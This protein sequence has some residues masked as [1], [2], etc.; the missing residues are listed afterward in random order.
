M[1][2]SEDATVEVLR[3]KTVP[4][5]LVAWATVVQVSDIQLKLQITGGIVCLVDRQHVNSTYAKLVDNFD[6]KTP[7]KKANEPPKL[8][9]LFHKGQQYV[10]KILER[11]TRA[12]YAKAQDI[13][14]TL[15]PSHIQEDNLPATMLSIANVPLQGV[16]LSIED[17]GYHVDIGFK[18]VTAFLNFDQTE[19]GSEGEQF[20]VGQVIRCC[21]LEAI[22]LD[23]NETRVV[24]LSTTKAMFKKAHFSRDK[25]GQTL[26]TQKCVLPGSTGFLTVMKVRRDGLIVNFL[27][28]FAGFVGLSHL[29]KDREEPRKG[30][31]IADTIKCTVLYYNPMTS[32]FALS[33]KLKKTVRSTVNSLLQSHYVGQTISNAVVVFIN[34]LR[35]VE[36]KVGIFRALANVTDALE[37]DVGT[38]TKDEIHMALDAAYP[39]GSNHKCRIKSINYADLTIVLS[40]RQEFLDLPYVS[41]EELRPAHFIEATIKKHVRDGIV[42]SFGLN[43]RAIILNVHLN[44]KASVSSKSAAHKTDRRYPIGKKISCRVLKVDLDKQPARVYLTDKEELMQKELTVID[45]YDKSFRGETV[46]AVVWKLKHDGII[47]ELFNNVKGFVPRR[48]CSTVPIR[49]VSDLFH[50]GQVISCTVYRVEPHRQSL[51]LGIIPYEKIMA[52]KKEAKL[53]RDERKKLKELNKIDRQV[54]RQSI[55]DKFKKRKLAPMQVDGKRRKTMSEDDS[56]GDSEGDSGDEKEEEDGEVDESDDEEGEVEA[57]EGVEENQVEDNGQVKR[58]KSRLE[59][60]IEA[61]QRE[62]RVREAERNLLDP[63]RPAQSIGDF[64]RLLLKTPNS[65]EAWIKYSV[66]FLDNVET[67]KARIVCRRALRTINFRMEKEKLRIWLQL[68]KIEAK[69][70]GAERLRA[71]IEEATQTSDKLE[72]YLRASKVLVTCGELGEAGRLLEESIRLN[73]KCPDGWIEYATFLMEH[74]KD[75]HE[76]RQ[77]FDRAVKGPLAPNDLVYLRSRFAHLELKTGDVERGKTLFENLLSE[78]PKRK[79]LWR[80]Y[81][82]AIRKF[83]TRQLDTEEVRKQNELILQ[84]IATLTN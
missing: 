37:Q 79:D 22:Q 71:I 58:R 6:S 23:G 28:E 70:G 13:I 65:A 47:V 73:R 41:V 10:C 34:S 60:S 55:A 50:V 81:E 11:Q 2:P 39:E 82:A 27:D 56:E 52:M 63:N 32:T 14:A 33:L 31:K 21:T 38:M 4:D 77:L 64:E 36:F 42:V 57:E 72:L 43:L 67:E 83:G 15:D 69:Y 45:S 8:G 12:G 40:L 80:V 78:N 62:E 25:C 35:Y 19:D 5:N 66:F 18:N 68:I 76:A 17:H 20:L 75:L 61:K 51:L 59:R 16:V 1:D 49:T 24:Q 74:K 7:N 3:P 44:D 26:L 46:C 29:R 53:A 30:Y 54:E 48:F 84:R 9:Q